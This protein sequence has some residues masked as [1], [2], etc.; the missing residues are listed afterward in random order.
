MTPVP[1]LR[2]G[3]LLDR[4]SADGP[5]CG[6]GA[7]AGLT[8]YRLV[9]REWPLRIEAYH[10]R[11][12][13]VASSPQP[14]LQFDVTAPDGAARRITLFT[15]TVDVAPPDA[16]RRFRVASSDPN[17]VPISFF[18]GD[19]RELPLTGAVLVAEAWIARM[20]ISTGAEDTLRYGIV[21][22]EGRLAGVEG[23]P[24]RGLPY[25]R[26]LVFGGD[27]TMT[28]AYRLTAMTNP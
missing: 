3:S 15:G 11:V 2:G 14:T 19:P 17:G 18:V 5:V 4:R 26:G 10:P 12:Q 16:G 27:L 28:I 25:I 21:G 13:V 23:N 8:L 20:P 1:L 22:A 6:Y 7:I 9:A 24:G